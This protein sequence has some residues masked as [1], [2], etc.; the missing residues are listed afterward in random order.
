MNSWYSEEV[1]TSVESELEDD[2]SDVVSV[3]EISLEGGIADDDGACKLLIGL[4]VELMGPGNEVD[5]SGKG[6]SN[7]M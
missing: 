1:S 5:G 2:S 4:D 6:A 3:D 7:G